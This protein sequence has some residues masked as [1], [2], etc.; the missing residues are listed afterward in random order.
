MLKPRSTMYCRSLSTKEKTPCWI[1]TFGVKI[2]D[3]NKVFCVYE[4]WI[5][6]QTA[7]GHLTRYFYSPSISEDIFYP[8]RETC[9]CSNLHVRNLLEKKTERIN[10]RK[11]SP[12][13]LLETRKTNCPVSFWFFKWRYFPSSQGFS[14]SSNQNRTEPSL[15]LFTGSDSLSSG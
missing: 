1:Q 3:K 12:G 8:V 13:L 15:K 4:G 10:F 14:S 5:V 9:L 2:W 11:D 6:R 7:V